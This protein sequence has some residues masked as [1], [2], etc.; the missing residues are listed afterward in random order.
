MCLNCLISFI[1]VASYSTHRKIGFLMFS[2]G[3]E[4]DQCHEMA[5][6]ERAV[7]YDRK[8]IRYFEQHLRTTLSVQKKRILCRRKFFKF[9]RKTAVLESV[10]MYLFK[11]NSNTAV[12]PVKFA[13]LL[14]TPILKNICEQL[15]LCR[16]RK[17]SIIL[18][19]LGHHF[20]FSQVT[21]SSKMISR[22][23]NT[24]LIL[25]KTPKG[26]TKIK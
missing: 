20:G 16:R 26:N 4:R 7:L 19:L 25:C 6:C 1:P 22:I 12:V 10:F 3:I 14:R 13:K 8:S 17:N 5:Q 24:L 21:N 9:H 11:K 2:G 15:L 18:K 23:S